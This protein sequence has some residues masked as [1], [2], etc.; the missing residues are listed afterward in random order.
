[1][2]VSGD[3]AIERL[4][5]FGGHVTVIVMGDGKAGTPVAATAMVK[6]RLLGWHAQLSRF[7]PASELCALNAAP[8]AT[9]PVSAVVAR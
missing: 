3:E 6:R 7:D 2:R 1:V 9:V 8:R 4:E 5:C